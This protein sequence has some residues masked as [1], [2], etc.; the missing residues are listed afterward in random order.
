MRW[1]SANF[2]F[3]NSLTKFK[4]NNLKSNT[5]SVWICPWAWQSCDIGLARTIRTL[6]RTHVTSS[7]SNNNNL[8][9]QHR[10][11][12]NWID[13]TSTIFNLWKNRRIRIL[14]CNNVNLTQI[15]H[16]SQHRDWW[17]R[18]DSISIIFYLRHHNLSFIILK[19]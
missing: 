4:F 18:R 14:R 2:L 6:Q 7:L 16:I 15:I 17:N 8:S 1:W 3:A 13:S 12:C 9:F 5:S 11:W 10:V 19:F